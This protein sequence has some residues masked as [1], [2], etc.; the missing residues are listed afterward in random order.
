[1]PASMEM[2][3][4]SNV[5]SMAQRLA[6]RAEKR[7]EAYKRRAMADNFMDADETDTYRDMRRTVM[8]L[9]QFADVQDLATS[10]AR[11]GLTER[12]VRRIRDYIDNGTDAA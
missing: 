8:E 1:M 6:E 10:L 4:M 7:A 9:E 3:P 2:V 12:N 11:V 5:I